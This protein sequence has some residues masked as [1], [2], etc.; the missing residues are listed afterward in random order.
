ME[1]F[2]VN[3]FSQY[4]RKANQWFYRTADRAL[5]EAY[6]AALKIKAIEDEHFGGDKIVISTTDSSNQKR[7][8]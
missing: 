4:W 8:N 7:H 1:S 3:R 2:L 5:D 6:K